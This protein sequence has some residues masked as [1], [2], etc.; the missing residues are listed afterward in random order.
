[1]PKHSP[2]QFYNNRTEMKIVK[3]KMT[4]AT[5]KRISIV[6]S[7]LCFMIIPHDKTRGAPDSLSRRILF[8]P[9][10]RRY[11]TTTA[12]SDLNTDSGKRGLA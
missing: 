12:D 7:S 9:F 1:M 3:A 2:P 10:A 6:I 5:S 4:F 11:Q 8:A